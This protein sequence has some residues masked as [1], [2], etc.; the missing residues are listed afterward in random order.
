MTLDHRPVDPADLPLLCT[1]PQNARELF[2]LFPTATYPLTI[3]PLAAA[4][5][6][7]W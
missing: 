4:S 5:I 1:F 6:P 3:E 7:P 2:F